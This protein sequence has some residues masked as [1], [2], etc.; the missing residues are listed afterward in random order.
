MNKTSMT[1]ITWTKMSGAGNCFWIAH[2][3]T[4][5]LPPKTN[6]PEV[7]HQLCRPKTV[8]GKKELEGG[9]DG[10]ALLLPSKECDF[11]W[12]FYNADGSSAEMCGNLACCVTEYVFIK[13]LIPITKA[14]VTLETPAG[15]IKGEM[16][17]H[18]HETG[19]ATKTKSPLGIKKEK[20]SKSLTH[21]RIFLKQSTDI[22]GPFESIFERKTTTYMF[23][24][25][26]VPHAVIKLADY[27]T[28]PM[29]W[30]N[31]KP[32]ARF[33]RSQTQHHKDGMNVS[34]YGFPSEQ[35][36]GRAK[37]LLAR[38]FER[39]VEDWTPACGTGALAVAQVYSHQH[40]PKASEGQSFFVQ[41]P[42][43]EL[44]VE[45]HANN[46]LSLM[47]PVQWLSQKTE[48]VWFKCVNFIQLF[49]I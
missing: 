14:F 2:F 37:R 7:A 9:A 26:A 3:P 40:P 8:A 49:S 42:G 15:I 10:M 35:M 33:L 34:F 16:K 17:S 25:S 4:S 48:P 24:N 38:S 45:F 21:P 29:T 47:S 39:G 41:M 44:K 13:K 27:P 43:G 28:S 36:D 30:D 5:A 6:W 18:T 46:M 32:L 11:K 12:L 19:L 20:S 22:Q 1:K 31:L 23:I